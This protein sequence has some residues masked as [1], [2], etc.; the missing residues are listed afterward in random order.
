MEDRRL[1]ERRQLIR[2]DRAD[3]QPDALI[4]DVDAALQNIVTDRD[5]NPALAA[6]VR[7]SQKSANGASLIRKTE[8]IADA[9]K[10]KL[11]RLIIFRI[12]DMEKGR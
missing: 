5:C 4:R 2:V 11:G 8:A 12:R 7:Y 9:E 3:S 1:M 6:L 10:E